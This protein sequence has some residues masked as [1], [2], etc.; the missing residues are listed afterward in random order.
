VSE[1]CRRFLLRCER[2]ELF[3]VTSVGV[4]LEVTHRLMVSEAVAAG[5][6]PAGRAVRRL[7]EHPEVVKHLARYLEQVAEISA[8]GVEVRPVD[9]GVCL[10]AA[11]AS[12]RYGLLTNDA[13]VVATMADGN[14]EG[15]A[16]SDT[17]FC[18]V[19]GLRVYAPTD[20]ESRQPPLA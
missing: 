10:R 4:L 18:R 2:G 8:W 17:D 20:L 3:G 11:E 15:I 9:L 13:L 7:Q 12:G 1:Q 14:I 19:A 5:L 6:V 16:T